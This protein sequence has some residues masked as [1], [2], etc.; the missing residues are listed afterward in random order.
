M[1]I[2]TTYPTIGKNCFSAIGFIRNLD[3]A[4]DQNS[5][6]LEYFGNKISRKDYW[7]TIDKYR[8]T[9]LSL[10]IGKGD[11]VTVCMLNSPE[12]EF[13][14][15]ALLENGSV[16]S[17][18]SK[19]FINADF[20]RQTIERN[21]KVL[22]ISIEFVEELIKH[23]AF[24]QLGN[25]CGD[26]KLERIIFTTCTDYM[27]YEQKSKMTI[28]D[29][30]ALI[31][32][33]SLPKNIEVTYPGELYKMA[34]SK[35]KINLPSCNLLD[36]IATYSNTGGTTGAPKCAMHTH[37][38]IV[39]ILLSH[40]RNT[41]K[42]FNMKEHSRSLLVIPI[43]HITSQFYA[44][45]IR[46]AYGANI[47]YN[48]FSFDPAVLREILIKEKIDD[49]TLPF[50]LYYAITRKP[51]GKDELQILTPLCGGE[52][53]PY[54]PTKSVNECF[55]K[56]GSASLI[57]GTGSTEFGS[58]VMATYGIEDRINE[59]GC[60]FPYASGFLL[61]SKTGKEITEVGK[62]GILY[63]NA[64]WQME[65]YLNDKKATDEFFNITKN[66][67]KYGTNNDIVE[68]VGEH[69]GK[70]IYSMLGRATDFVLTEN[71]QT[72]YQG[73]NMSEGRVVDTDFTAGDF[74][75]DMRDALLNI[76]GV[77]EVQPVILP[78]ADGTKDGYPVADITIR[79]D[80][81]PIDIL[82][83]IYNSN[84]SFAPSGIVFLTRFER[85]L[86][87]DKRE[88]M[89]LRDI[90]SGYYIIENDIC[91]RLSFPKGANPQK[92]VVPNMELVKC[93]EPPAPKLVYSSIRM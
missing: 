20:K 24:A 84:A 64:P 18:V 44:L 39:S 43:S 80:C 25:N 74:L 79:K 46:R 92:E 31:S 72:Y 89:S 2:K 5:T 8:A 75:F 49:V 38:A 21:A 65:G 54:M 73:I 55:H 29:Y 34:Q 9:F 70:P 52:P 67:V 81:K 14:F 78:K 32:A 77:M 36:E 51:F 57:I 41:Y 48:P 85:S 42:E 1:Q 27:P 59:S 12:Y 71:K 60:F 53:T 4:N 15:S 37:K 40:D 83:N 13:V 33:I 56:A 88:V 91:Y 50:G 93:I 68:I 76:D 19:S 6:A 16:A 17:T 47:I 69:N 23:G 45:L 61:D 22:I 87:S 90:R 11:V 35:P 10:G 7:A 82:R 28:A 86:A 62:R 66:G 30:K 26:I 58:G 63:A 3:K